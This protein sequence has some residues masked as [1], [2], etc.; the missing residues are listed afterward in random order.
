LAVKAG[1]SL[2]T[3]PQT[4][5]AQQPAVR[6]ARQVCLDDKQVQGSMAV[7]GEGNVYLLGTYVPAAGV[8]L[9]HADRTGGGRRGVEGCFVTRLK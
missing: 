3:N 8:M 1:S 6:R 2:V 7:A 4:Y 9:L 5:F